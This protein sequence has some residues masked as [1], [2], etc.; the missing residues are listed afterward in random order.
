MKVERR[1]TVSKEIIVEI[2][3]EV[4]VNMSVK[5]ESTLGTK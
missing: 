5:I 1:E 3:L 4:K 2:F